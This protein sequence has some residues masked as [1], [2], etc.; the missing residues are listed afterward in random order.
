LKDGTTKLRVGIK[1]EGKAPLRE[2]TELLSADGRKI[3]V[4]TSG[5][6]GPS[7]DGPVAMGYVETAF[8]ALGTRLQVMLRGTAR[9]CEVAALPFIKANYKRD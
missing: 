6:F 1:P 4:I 9:P 8:S 5:G 7:V 3:G 2:G